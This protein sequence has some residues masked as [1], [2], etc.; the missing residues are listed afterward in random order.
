[1]SNHGL[2]NRIRRLFGLH[3]NY[4]FYTFLLLFSIITPLSLW[5]FLKPISS[6]NSSSAIWIGFWGSFLGAIIGAVITYIVMMRTFVENNKN[7]KTE[8]DVSFN[9]H[10]AETLRNDYREQSKCINHF[11]DKL[12]ELISDFQ[13]KMFLRH[14][15]NESIDEVINGNSVEIKAELK[16]AYDSIYD[17]PISDNP[18]EEYLNKIKEC[19]KSINHSID[20]YSSAVRET[21]D[22]IRKMED[23]DAINNQIDSK[24]I[25]TSIG[26]TPI[27]TIIL[28]DIFDMKQNLETGNMVT[29]STSAFL[30]GW[31]Y[32]SDDEHSICL[33]SVTGNYGLFLISNYTLTQAF[34]LSKGTDR[35][36]EVYRSILVKML[37]RIEAFYELDANIKN[38]E[39]SIEQ[40]IRSVSFDNLLVIPVVITREKVDSQY[41]DISEKD[42]ICPISI[43]EKLRQM[44]QKRMID[45][46]YDDSDG[47]PKCRLEIDDQLRNEIFCYADDE[48]EDDASGVVFDESKY[49]QFLEFVFIDL[50]H[51]EIS[52]IF[53]DCSIFLEILTQPSEIDNIHK[54]YYSAIKKEL[55][56]LTSN[57]N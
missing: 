54:G 28:A 14:N 42:D 44:I 19:Y 49:I 50:A 9:L 30:D 23:E 20:N 3:P 48:Y 43:T 45:S 10:R 1:M 55:S 18:S 33:K 12:Q 53:K 46:N 37:H 57:E 56:K 6:S 22:Y 38:F 13:V 17:I 26:L 24:Y 40:Y 35:L 32:F 52:H 16:K 25:E 29:S 27:N 2:I 41:C 11:V 21:C 7:N 36:N 47:M 4:T 15:V 34:F 8:R 5:F 31:N 51:P 39:N